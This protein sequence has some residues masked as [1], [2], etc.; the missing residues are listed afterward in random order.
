MD[1]F[2]TMTNYAQTQYYYP[3]PVQMNQYGHMHQRMSP[4]MLAN[5]MGYSP[6]N[7]ASYGNYGYERNMAGSPAINLLP[8]ENV[9]ETAAKDSDE[10]DMTTRSTK[11]LMRSKLS[12][13]SKA[14]VKKPSSNKG[15]RKPSQDTKA[16]TEDEG[17]TSED[18]DDMVHRLDT[19]QLKLSKGSFSCTANMKFGRKFT[20][21]DNQPAYQVKFKT[22][23]CKNWQAG[24]C[25][26][27]NKCSFAHGVEELTEKKHL[28][29]NYKTKVCK[30][31][32]EEN[33]CSYGARCQFIHLADA[34]QVQED[35]LRDAILNLAGL[36]AKKSPT[37]G[38]LSVFKNLTI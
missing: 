23:L 9:D 24:D 7:N 8:C 13:K 10:E 19:S 17:N 15:D 6:L 35:V 16:H 18:S 5:Q 34:E 3:Q 37:T 22:E 27:G 14:F 26:F 12:Y 32:H 1:N 21:L 38:R 4:D 29:N 30:Q 31:F 36:P 11:L 25:K 28:P 2:S 33:Y 20:S